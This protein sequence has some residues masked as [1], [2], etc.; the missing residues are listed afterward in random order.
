[1]IVIMIIIFLDYGLFNLWI[2][3]YDLFSIIGFII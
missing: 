2:V 1:M 3:F